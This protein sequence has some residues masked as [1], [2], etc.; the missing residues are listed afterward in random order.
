MRKGARVLRLGGHMSGNAFGF[1][2]PDG[3]RVIAVQNPFPYEKTVSFGG[4]VCALAP[5]SVSTLVFAE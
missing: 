1:A 5:Q 3:T 4:V 2:N